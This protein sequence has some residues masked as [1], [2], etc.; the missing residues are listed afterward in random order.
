MIR[1]TLDGLV[2]R[3][4]RESVVDGASLEIPPGELTFLL[5]PSGAGK[6][7]LARLIA[8]LDRLDAGEIYFDQRL[9]HNLPPASRRVGLVFQDDALWPLMTVA[10]NVAYPLRLL[11]QTRLERRDRVAEMLSVMRIDSLAAK[12]PGQLSPLQ[13]QRVALAR[14]LVTRPELLILDEPLGR[15]ENR[16]R[17]EFREEIR[18]V[19]AEEDISTLVLT[20]DAREALGLAERLAVMD[21][22]RIVQVGTPQEVYNRPLD[23][24]VARF[25]GQTNLLQGHVESADS[26]GE[27]VVRTPFGRMV[28]QAVHGAIAPGA[29]VTVAIRP[30]SIALGPGLPA[31]ANR[32]A[33]T[34]ER[35]V[36]QGEVRQ[37]HL[38]GP[39]DW[40]VIATA[41]QSQSNQLRE[42]Q[43]LTIGIPPSLVVIL[44]G[45]YAMPKS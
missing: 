33:A 5:G 2:K 45:K 4:D 29:P 20:N 15:L 38:R 14:A 17:D 19:H 28:G 42:G 32:F 24:F 34:I 12:L 3:F 25:L 11:G 36:F 41:L 21:L 22:G 30:E 31:N 1:V 16:V 27:M 43:S 10:D 37:I 40:P 6:T 35:L 23:A 8:G 13:R 18:R 44:V 39:G 7:V 26:K 9:V